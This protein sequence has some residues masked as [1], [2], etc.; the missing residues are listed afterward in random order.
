MLNFA[1]ITVG[2]CFKTLLNLDMGKLAR[3]T[4]P[5]NTAVISLFEPRKHL[6]SLQ[7]LGVDVYN[8]AFFYSA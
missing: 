4:A 8:A 2:N 5:L 1:L 7:T 6:Q 3:G